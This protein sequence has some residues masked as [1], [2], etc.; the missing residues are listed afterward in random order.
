MSDF[1]ISTDRDRLDIDLIHR[2]LS[3]TYW[4]AGRSRETVVRSIQHSLCFGVYRAGD[5]VAFGRVIT[6]YAVFGYV[7][8]VF[9]VP[10]WR[11]KGIA[12]LLMDA[13]SRHP[14]L[15]QLQVTLLRTRDAHGLYQ[16]FGFEAVRYPE[17]MMGRWRHPS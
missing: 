5:Q 17:Q 8:D 13:I 16:Q 3:E 7:A 14:D 12:K 4:A 9:V 10:E 1:D 11:G 6:D 15:Q 2:I